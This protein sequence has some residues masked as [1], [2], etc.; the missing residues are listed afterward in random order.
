MSVAL[1]VSA[2]QVANAVMNVHAVFLLAV[3]VDDH[4]VG[5]CNICA[6]LNL[7]RHMTCAAW[8]ATTCEDGLISR[9]K[10]SSAMCPR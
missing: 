3:P 2:C 9:W 6:C 5:H 7:L 1:L 4:A 8:Y 10:H